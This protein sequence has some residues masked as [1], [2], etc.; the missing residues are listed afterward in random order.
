MTGPARTLL[1]RPE[2]PADAP[3]T[4]EVTRRA[5]TWDDGVAENAMIQCLRASPAAR[6]CWGR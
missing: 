3:A 1:L 5:F 4:F 6:C 2:Q